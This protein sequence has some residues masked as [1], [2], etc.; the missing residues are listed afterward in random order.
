MDDHLKYLS[1]V[2]ESECI[3][4]SKDPMKIM[5]NLEIGLDLGIP[6]SEMVSPKFN[7]SKTTSN[8]K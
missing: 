1:S 6:G 5:K 4:S 8:K 7:E 3:Q 2:N